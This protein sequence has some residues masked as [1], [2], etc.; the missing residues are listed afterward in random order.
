VSAGA[1]RDKTAAL[2]AELWKKNRP[3]MLERIGSLEALVAG[4]MTPESRTEAIGLAHKF[5]GS[6]GMF[7][8]GEGTR[9]AREIE[10]LLEGGAGVEAVRGLVGKLRTVVGS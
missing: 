4:E 10:L 2:L 5:A 9:L 8:F 6:L 7:G 1:P 3:L